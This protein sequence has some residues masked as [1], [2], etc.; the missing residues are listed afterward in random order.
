MATRSIGLTGRDYSTL[1]AWAS[2]VNALSLSAPEIGEVYRDGGPV[3]DTAAVIFSGY[4]GASATNT[5][6]LR[7]AAGQGFKDHASASTNA[8]RYNDTLGAA[9]TNNTGYQSVDG[10]YRLGAFMIVDGLQI[11]STGGGGSRG[12]RMAGTDVTLKN[13]IVRANSSGAVVFSPGGAGRLIQNCVLQAHSSGDGINVEG[14]GV[15]LTVEGCTI[16]KIGAASGGGIGAGYSSIVLMRNTVVFGFTTNVAVSS[17]A[18]FSASCANNA[19][20]AASWN[21][22]NAA[23]GTPQYSLAA[24]TDLISV[25]SGSENLR[26]VST[27]TKLVNTATTAGLAIDIFGTARPQGAAYDIGAHEYAAPASALSG[28]AILS[29]ITADGSMAPQ[30]NSSLSGT[31]ILSGIAADGGMG[32]APGVITTPVLKNN[33]GTTLAWVSGI[34]ANIYHPTTGALVVRKTGLTSDGSGIVTIS[35]VLLSAGT[36]Y[37]YELD[38]SASSQGRRLPTG[39]AA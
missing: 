16:V 20:N 28:E 9:L 19:T 10:V 6:T 3:A 30:P 35:D 29:G 7:P 2:Y 25:T 12:V 18:T 32:L 14:N 15:T 37:A 24:G 33:T 4:T 22:A 1:A 34:V 17:G 31:A 23:N 36:T 39:V 38:L 21:V 5:I 27:S 11:L 13:S 8:L 26:A